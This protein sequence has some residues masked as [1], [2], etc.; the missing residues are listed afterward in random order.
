MPCYDLKNLS[1]SVRKYC[2]KLYLCSPAWKLLNKNMITPNEFLT[3]AANL[4][5]ELKYGSLESKI[6][7]C[8]ELRD[9]PEFELKETPP[10]FNNGMYM[11]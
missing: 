5:G 7:H 3:R 1:H 6:G 2:N 10:D 8:D 11:I 9:G 4:K